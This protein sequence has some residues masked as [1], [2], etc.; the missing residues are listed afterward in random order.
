MSGVTS[1]WTAPP[2]ERREPGSQ[3][4]ERDALEAWLDYHRDTL[5]WKCADLTAEQLKERAVP[6]SALSLLGLVRHMTE[7]ERFWF[8]VTANDRDMDMPYSSK[9]NRNADFDDLD[10]ADA[11]ADLEAFR[12]EIAESKAAVRG[13][14]L[15]DVVPSHQADDPPC[16]IRS[17]YLHMIEEYA[18]H[19]GHADLIRERIDGLTGD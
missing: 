6:P 3:L 17:I 14:R 8:R 12:R 11:E 9:D 1:D 19:N 16:D 10:D 13:K 4:G 7:V 5:L 18:R 15:D 2:I